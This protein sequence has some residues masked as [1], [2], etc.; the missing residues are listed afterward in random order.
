MI[1]YFS[2]LFLFL[3]SFFRSRCNLGIEIVALRQQLGVLNRKRP[4]PH[5]RIGDRLFWVWLHRLWPAWKN[6]LIV[7]KPQTVVA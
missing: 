3:S 2:G 1:S 6:A 7:V 4:R 5:L